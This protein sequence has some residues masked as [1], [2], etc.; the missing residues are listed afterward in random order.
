L[1]GGKTKLTSSKESL[2]DETPANI[3]RIFLETHEDP[4]IDAIASEVRRLQLARGLDDPQKVKVVLEALID[5]SVPKNV[6]TEYKKHSK[7]LHR[8]ARDRKSRAL[9]IYCIEDQIGVLKPEL[10]SRMPMILQE[11]YDTDVL[12]EESIL[13]WAD[14]PAEQSWLVPKDVA[15][16]ARQKAGPFV[17]WLKEADEEGDEGDSD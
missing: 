8:F 16:L 10:I 1:H 7:V 13:A 9:L 15:E 4:S 11:L 17:E 2:K 5:L 6:P 3:L 14:S 12:D